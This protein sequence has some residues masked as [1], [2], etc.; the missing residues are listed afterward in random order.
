MSHPTNPFGAFEHDEYRIEAVRLHLLTRFWL[1]IAGM[2]TVTSI[3]LFS[4]QPL[5]VAASL[6]AIFQALR[7]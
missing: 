6:G 4:D 7:R 5:A 3:C 2:C 1:D